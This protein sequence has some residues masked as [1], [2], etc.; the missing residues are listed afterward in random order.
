MYPPSTGVARPSGLMAPEKTTFGRPRSNS[1]A[2]PGA[3]P[4]V[5]IPTV[6]TPIISVQP[7]APSASDTASR[8]ATIVQGSTSRPP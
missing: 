1:S 3:S 4:A 8:A 5:A 2:T 6:S 7:L